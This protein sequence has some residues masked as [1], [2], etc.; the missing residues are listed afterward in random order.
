MSFLP[1]NII[2]IKWGDRYGADYVNRL[3]SSVRRH[4]TCPKKVVCFTDDPL[5]IDPTVEVHPI[6]EIDLPAEAMVNGWRKL[7]LLRTDLLLTHSIDDQFVNKPKVIDRRGK[8][9]IDDIALGTILAL[10]HVGY[11]IFD[12]GGCRRPVTI[13]ECIR[14]IEQ[15]LG[16]SAMIDRQP[17]HQ[18]EIP[19]TAAVIDKTCDPLHWSPEIDLT[20]HVQS[21]VRWRFENETQLAAKLAKT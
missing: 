17:F 19:E 9:D 1:H 21:A 15:A 7:C 5:G 6:T 14:L 12:L 11:E 16:K 8:M 18:G 4:T 13:L 3:A 2:T 20:E 10:H